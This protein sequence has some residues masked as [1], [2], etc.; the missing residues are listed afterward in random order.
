MSVVPC[1]CAFLSLEGCALDRD[2]GLL[3]DGTG[4]T[5][6]SL[7]AAADVNDWDS[8]FDAAADTAP[9]D[10][11]WPDAAG[12]DVL[13][14]DAAD[15]GVAPDVT[16]DVSEPDSEPDVIAQPDV[17]V[18][19]VDGPEAAVSPFCDDQDPSLAACYRFNSSANL[20]RDRSQYGNHA[21][22]SGVSAVPGVSG[23]A[24]LHD[25]N[26]SM[27]VAD[28][29]SL[30]VT[31]L[32]IELWIKPYTLPGNRAGLF[33]NDGQYGFFLMSS[34]AVRCSAGS[35]AVLAPVSV[36]LGV[37]THVACTYD[38]AIHA[39]FIN[40]VQ[41]ESTAGSGAMS[42]SSATGSCIGSNSPSGDPFDGELD[43]LRIWQYARSEQ[44]ICA[45]AGACN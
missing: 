23:S 19:V 38:G 24:V 18:D 37:W 1:L 20:G 29:P 26:S 5:H 27:R 45:A 42:T 28:S 8:A 32:T 3:V 35:G 2:G 16:S 4:G 22:V 10:G 21:T 41:V 25:A 40:G 39:L 44:E 43:E 14:P 34:G 36:D 7:D 31:A 15:D 11:A 12:A 30:D 33:D 13:A 6:S 17:A 9:A